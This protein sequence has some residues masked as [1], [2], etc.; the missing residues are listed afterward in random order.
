MKNFKNKLALITGGSSGIGLALA[1]ILSSRGAHVYLL[2]RRP[3]V[4][5][6][7]LNEVEE[8]ALTTEQHFGRL[9]VDVANLEQVNT[10]LAAFMGHTGVPDLLVN[11]A[12]VTQPGQ[13]EEQ[14]PELFRDRKSVV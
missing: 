14:D 12:G 2:A 13:F 1:K 6:S 9:A 10:E 7:A 5:Q 11:S 3:D 8:A 4:L